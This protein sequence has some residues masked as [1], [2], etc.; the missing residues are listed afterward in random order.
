M[1]H[2][3]TRREEVEEP[4][5]QK[6]SPGDAGQFTC[7]TA[8]QSGPARGAETVLLVEDQDE[9]RVLIRIGLQTQG[10]T[11]LTAAD[12]REALQVVERQA[13]PIHLIV[14]DLVMPG[15]NGPELVRRLSELRPGI[16]ALF[17]SGHQRSSV[18]ERSG[19]AGE[20]AFLEKP[21]TQDALAKKVREVLAK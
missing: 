10:Y 17:V 21:F 3:A 4:R 7:T 16:R 14:A 19:L 18:L 15:M 12:G 20:V 13:G 11:V 8:A 2:Q 9:V 5:P 1:P 6:P